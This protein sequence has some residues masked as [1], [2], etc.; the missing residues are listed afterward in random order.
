M[1]ILKFGKKKKERTQ[2]TSGAKKRNEIF[3]D[4]KF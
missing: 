1:K 3:F 4:K 2:D